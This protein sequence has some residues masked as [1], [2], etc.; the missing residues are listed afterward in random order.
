MKR[1]RDIITKLFLLLRKHGVLCKK[2]IYRKPVIKIAK[3]VYP[4]G[5]P[6][7]SLNG[8]DQWYGLQEMNV[9]YKNK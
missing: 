5:K 2:Y 8:K 1:K 9:N 4:E 7:M 6:R 3:T